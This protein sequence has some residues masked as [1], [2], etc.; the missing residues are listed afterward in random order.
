MGEIL[1]R[2][3]DFFPLPDQEPYFKGQKNIDLLLCE[4]L[5][6][7]PH[8]LPLTSRGNK[9]SILSLKILSYLLGVWM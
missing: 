1:E 7:L 2:D 8:N 6:L 3:E 5:S 9:L 4:R